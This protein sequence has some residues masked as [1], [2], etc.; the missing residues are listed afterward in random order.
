MTVFNITAGRIAGP[1]DSRRSQCGGRPPPPFRS[2]QPSLT[3]S[4]DSARVVIGLPMYGSEEFVGAV[5]ESLLAQDHES[6]AVIAVDDCSPDRTL[7]IARRHAAADPRLHVEANPKRLGMIGNWNRALERAYDL[8]PG[9]GYFA[10]ASDNDLREPAWASVLVQ[11]LEEDPRAALAYSR[12]GTIVAGEK[13]V[14]DHAKW[15]FETREIADPFQRLRTASDGLRAGPIMYG[16]HRRS[17]LDAAGN[18]PS[19]LLSDFVFLSH[20][21]LYGTFLQAPE[22]LWYRDLRRTTGSSTRRQRAAL[23]A[24]PPR[25][26]YLPVSIQHT[27]WLLEQL[28]VRGRRPSGLGRLQG[29]GISLYYLAKWWSRLL[30]RGQRQTEKRRRKLVKRFRKWLAPRRKRVARSALGGLLRRTL[31]GLRART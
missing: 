3:P 26:T 19:V 2:M 14:P 22:V 25:L 24:D 29:L 1:P 18:V 21:S 30:L 6:L 31:R 5:I 15:L 17:T 8:H 20:L 7:E 16:L 28:V 27:V 4:R 9:F 23:F 13:V 11:A 10:W 12:F